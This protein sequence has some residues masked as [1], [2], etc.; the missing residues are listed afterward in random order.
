MEIPC[1]GKTRARRKSSR[2]TAEKKM[3]IRSGFIAQI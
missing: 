3:K 1:R 2:A